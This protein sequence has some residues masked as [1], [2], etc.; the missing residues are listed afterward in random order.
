[1]KILALFIKVVWKKKLKTHAIKK[2]LK[3]TNFNSFPAK[4][5]FIVLPD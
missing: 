2:C 4:K 5:G 1:M 3:I